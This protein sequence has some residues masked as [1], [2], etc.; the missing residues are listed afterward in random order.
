VMA[1]HYAHSQR[2]LQTAVPAGATGAV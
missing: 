2:V 1:E